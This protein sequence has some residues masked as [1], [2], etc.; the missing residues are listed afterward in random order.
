MMFKILRI[1]MVSFL[2]MAPSQVWAVGD[3]DQAG[4]QPAGE[5]LIS[6]STQVAGATTSTCLTGKPWRL[7]ELAGEPVS[8][9][10]AAPYLLFKDGGDFMGF[11]GCNYFIGKYRTGEDG[12]VVISS[13]RATNQHCADSSPRETTLLTSLVMASTMQLADT[14]LAFA[15]NGG[16]LLKL[17]PAPEIAVDDLLQQGK[18]LKAKKKR[19][20]K[21]RSKKK[22]LAKKSKLPGK[23]AAPKS[24]EKARPTAKAPIK[25]H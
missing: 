3:L 6:P 18:L 8:E 23:P 7:V 21:S 14:Q 1:F 19:G 10:Q 20:H 12:K 16:N 5:D 24:Y 9:E 4:E 11:G 17:D 13:L 15:M 2:F 22:R 25:A